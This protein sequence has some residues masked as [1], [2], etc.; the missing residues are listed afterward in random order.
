[1]ALRSFLGT[2]LVVS[3]AGAVLAAVSGYFLREHPFAAWIAAGV[4]LIESFAT[5]VLLGGK[6]AVVMA[7][8]H[9]LRSLRLGRSAVRLIFDRLLGAD[10]AAQGGEPGALVRVAERIPLAQAER[11]LTD[12]VHGLLDTPPAEGGQASWWR[13]RLHS[14]L[15][16][17]VRK[18]TLARFR[19]EGAES[20]GIDLV[21]VRVEVEETI[22]DRLVGRFRSGLNLWTLL[23][24]LGLPVAVFA[25]TWIVLAL[26][27]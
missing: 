2:V 6:R 15:L 8:V 3:L 10:P 16:D 7:L 11:R 5:G 19:Q 24:V 21:K 22:D 25:Q 9:G 12:A 18:Y 1:V 23:V 17:L 4:A 27:H 13:R 20:G 26:W 14:R